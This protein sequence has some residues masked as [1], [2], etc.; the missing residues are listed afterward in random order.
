MSR[1]FI[2]E[3]SEHQEELPEIPQSHNPGYITPG[4][5]RLLQEELE[6]LENV[7]RPPLVEELESGGA[8]A[9]EAEVQLARLDQRIRYL[10]ARIGRAIVINPADAPSD[11]VHFGSKV[12]VRDESDHEMHVHIVGEDE[13]D[14]DAG[15]VSCFSPLA[16][17]LMSKG[18]G[19]TAIWHRPLGDLR[20]TIVSIE[21]E[22][23]PHTTD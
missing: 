11:H 2:D 9:T 16:K 1:A 20:L 6:R 8:G 17:A 3:D 21:Q 14:P 23:E 5:Y 4:G 19:E 10:H 13:T 15:R 7:E 22:D 12:T 18:V